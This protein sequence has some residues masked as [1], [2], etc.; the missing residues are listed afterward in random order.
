MAQSD[1]QRTATV[2]WDS[3]ATEPLQIDRLPSQDEAARRELARENRDPA[4]ESQRRIEDPYEDS[5]LLYPDPSMWRELTK[6]RDRLASQPETASPEYS[7]GDAGGYPG[8][9]DSPSG[10]PGMGAGM[11]MPA[12]TP[13]K[14]ASVGYP[15]MAGMPGRPSRNYEP[16]DVPSQ[17]P[18]AVGGYGEAME[19]GYGGAGMDGM[20]MPGGPGA[21]PGMG[22]MNGPAPDG[23]TSF[24][25]PP[26][27]DVARNL[28]ASPGE[29][30]AGGDSLPALSFAPDA[31]MDALMVE[32]GAEE[33][34]SEAK[35]RP[36][37]VDK[38]KSGTW[39]RAK[40]TPNA[41][42][43]M[44]GDRD[45]LPLEGMQA[46]VLIDGFRARVLLDCYYFNDRNQQ[47]EGRFKLRLPNEASLYY[48]AFGESA[49]EYRPAVDQLAA[50][51]FLSVDLVRAA[52][53]DPE[54]ILRAR[55]GTWS[56][57]KEARVVPREKAAHAYSETVRRRVDPALVEWSGAGVFQTRLFPLMPNKLHRIVIGYDVTLQKDGEDLVYR[58]DL[59]EDLSQCMVDLNVAAIPGMTADVTPDARP[60]TSGGRA[61]YHFGKTGDP[62]VSVRLRGQGPIVLAGSDDETGDFFATRF[63]PELP[64]G[65]EKAGSSHAV[66][67]LDT[68]LSSRPEKF[69]VW[70]DMLEAVLTKNRGSLRQFA[71]L[72]FNI[73]SHWWKRE[74]TANTS[75]NVDALLAFCHSLSLEGATDLEQALA[76]A[77]H[78]EW[79]SAEEKAPETDLFLLSDGAITWGDMNQHRLSRVLQSG[80]GGSL[81]AYKTGLT[82]TATAVLDHLARE[83]GGAVFSVANQEEIQTA[84]TAHRRRPWKLL[85]VELPGGSD[86]LVAGRPQFV[87]PGQ[88]LTVVGRGQPGTKATLRLR[89]GGENKTVHVSFNRVVKS[90]LAP[91]AYGEIAVGQ[92]EDLGDD[93]EDV[94][95]AY[96]RHFRV[97]GKTCS[98]L[99]LE[100]EQ[101]YQRFG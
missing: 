74:Y 23:I 56:K 16:G 73:E 47:L 30:S 54:D 10:A 2:E 49:Y 64:A 65:E 29:K 94:S 69:N 39:R 100:S 77:T 98:L 55:E 31:D 40:A 41:S 20:G 45:E 24:M 11:G 87:Y 92:L 17:V 35:R 93:L 60:F 50:K 84:A 61:Y 32:P 4:P 99:M 18:P 52:G 88:S 79:L 78:L 12:N 101:D 75:E 14:E 34:Q 28:N 7:Y 86:I 1:A 21:Q 81:F 53:L 27:S 66:F 89:R 42:R 82:G 71:V 85:D 36:K 59:P 80:S 46:N 19:G 33:A 13:S 76:V 72:F 43:L 15:G 5:P 95:V 48:F 83:T 38:P 25:S 9:P 63:T 67:L 90:D 22:D 44:I 51:G 58:L 8:A 37:R 96:A 6:D 3:A 97:T 62:Q 70:L 26:S 91:R 68:S 57:V